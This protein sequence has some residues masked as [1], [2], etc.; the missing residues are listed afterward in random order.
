V[1]SILYIRRRHIQRQ[2]MWVK[3]MEKKKKERERER[4]RK[5]REKTGQPSFQSTVSKRLLYMGAL[6]A[7]NEYIDIYIYKEKKTTLL[8]L[9]GYVDMH[10]AECYIYRRLL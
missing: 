9:N 5:K 3:K 10:I 1:K 4:S 6:K 7:H 2:L 8:L